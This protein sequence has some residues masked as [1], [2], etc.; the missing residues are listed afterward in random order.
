MTKKCM[1]CKYYGS[2]TA[3]GGLSQRRAPVVCA[4]HGSY[5]ITPHDAY[6][7]EF[8]KYWEYQCPACSRKTCSNLDVNKDYDSFKTCPT[9]DCRAKFIYWIQPVPYKHS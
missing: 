6:C 1:D 8:S 3:G 7:G 9:C 5:P 4:T 2:M